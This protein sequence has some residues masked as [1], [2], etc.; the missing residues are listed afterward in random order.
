MIVLLNYP[1]SMDPSS[2]PEPKCPACGAVASPAVP[3]GHCM[4]C[5]LKLALAAGKSSSPA[6]P[7]KQFGDYELIREIARGGMGVIWEARQVSL[8]RIVAL[9]L[10]LDGQ[11]A[12]EAALTRFEF[13]AEAAATLD[14]PNI[15][16]I[17]EVGQH[18]GWSFLA[19]KL[20]EGG[21]LAD[22]M[23][24]G[25]ER[26]EAYT[27]AAELVAKI[28]RAVHFAHLRGILHRDLK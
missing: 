25:L 15:V 8:N 20:I 7:A 5:L 3:G 9:K 12:S 16:P 24:A 19:L 1:E 10:L 28:A 4:G 14:H 23:G 6:Q 11:F 18:E 27:S 17:Y 2:S 21:S 26:M 22:K 13:E